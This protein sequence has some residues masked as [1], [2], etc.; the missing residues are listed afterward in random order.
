MQQKE[1]KY[2]VVVD[3]DEELTSFTS[4]LNELE[5]DHTNENLELRLNS[6]RFKGQTVTIHVNDNNRIVKWQYNTST[7]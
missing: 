6:Y 7:E 5:I 1:R 4:K 3:S 2:S